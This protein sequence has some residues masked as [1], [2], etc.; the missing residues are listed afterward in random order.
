MPDVEIRPI[1]PEETRPIRQQVLRPHQR[2]EELNYPGDSDLQSLHVGAFV[3]GKM[4]GIASVY[5]QPPEGSDD[6]KAW[7]LRGMAT[8]PEVRGDGYG[9]KLLMACIR[10]VAVQGGGWLWCNGR[11]NVA[12]FYQRYGFQIE[13]DVVEIPGTGPHYYL[14]RPVRLE[15]ADAQT[16]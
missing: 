16:D 8:V 13:G 11:T 14:W 12:G 6:P 7:R 10:Y 15:D 9:G 3:D 2:I 1:T 5:Q 4:V